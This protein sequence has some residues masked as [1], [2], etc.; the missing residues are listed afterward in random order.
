MDGAME[1]ET[2]RKAFNAFLKMYFQSCREV[3]EEL[4]LEGITNRQ[5][6]YL[7][8]IE[9]NGS[10]TMSELAEAFD[11]SKPTVTEVVRKFTEA[12]LIE[13]N[14]CNEDHRVFNITLTERGALL[15]KTNIL[16]SDRALEKIFE[17]LDEDEVRT[18]IKLFDK[19]GQVE[20]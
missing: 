3:Y 17:R 7:R 14:R 10:M 18:L 1:K 13:K 6:Q 15:A 12:G 2:V 19:I 16:E 4:D 20:T 8:E 5:F 9:K 11:L